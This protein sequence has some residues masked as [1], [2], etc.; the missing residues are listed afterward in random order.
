MGWW[1]YLIDRT[2]GAYLVYWHG[3]GEP[4]QYQFYRCHGCRKIVTHRHI[5]TG[6][7]PCH[8]SIKISPAKVRTGEKIRLLLL[9]W[10]VTSNSVRRESVR[11]L[12]AL[13]LL[14]VMSELEKAK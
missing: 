8:E 1:G 3:I 14:S 7:C 12:K 9:P 2:L 6:G 13:S 10:T 5:V 11:R 4:H